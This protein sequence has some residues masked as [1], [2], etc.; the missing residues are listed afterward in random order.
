MDWRKHI[1]QDPKIC[2]GVPVIRG[3]RVMIDAVLADLANG[4][5]AAGVRKSYPALSD[6]DVRAVIAYAAESVLRVAPKS[7]RAKKVA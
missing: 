3:T 7:R 6:E 5:D 4:R 2:G 1:H